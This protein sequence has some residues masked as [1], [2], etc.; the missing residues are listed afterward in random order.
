M[1]RPVVWAT[2]LLASFTATSAATEP[3]SLLSSSLLV[4]PTKATAVTARRRLAAPSSFDPHILDNCTTPAR[5][6]EGLFDVVYVVHS[7]D[8]GPLKW[9]M[10]SLVCRVPSV[11]KVWVVSD[12]AGAVHA[13]V[14]ELRRDLGEERVGWHDEKRFPFKMSDVA[15]HLNCGRTCGWYFQQLLKMCAGDAIPGIRDY[16][17][18][19][20][21]LVWFGRSIQMVAGRDAASGQPTA[22]YYNTAAQRHKA[23]FDHMGRLTGG[24]VGRV[25]PAISGVSH[26]MIFKKDVMAAL[27][28]HCSKVHGGTPFWKAVLEAVLPKT[29]NAVSEYELYINYAMKFWP[30][31]VKLRHLTFANGP[32]P[33][34]VTN[35]GDESS[36]RGTWIVEAHGFEKQ[37]AID[38]KTGFGYVGYH[39]YAKRRYYDTP[40]K[41]ILPYCALGVATRNMGEY[42]VNRCAKARAVEGAD[43]VLPSAPAEG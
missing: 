2:S 40:Q 16:M 42:M 20:A 13:L 17:V 23:Y 32:R 3:S 19:D 12:D 27:Q 36:M 21:D 26:H 43:K 37:M 34:L 39:S 30:D 18:V 29:Y 9:G 8:L 24:S 10:R 6:A 11:G 22:Y 31:T 38:K 14:D 15:S 33:G 1:R 25:D 7:K 28:A 4:P 35:G 5:P 41:S